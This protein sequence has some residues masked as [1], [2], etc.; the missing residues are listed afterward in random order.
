MKFNGDKNIRL[1]IT[2]EWTGLLDW[3]TGC[4]ENAINKHKHVHQ[5]HP[6]KLHDSYKR[7]CITVPYNLSFGSHG[8]IHRSHNWATAE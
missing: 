5:L 8:M 3:T 2:V 6:C 7:S 1:A 4:V